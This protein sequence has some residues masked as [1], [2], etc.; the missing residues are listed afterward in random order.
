VKGAHNF[1]EHR[2]TLPLDGYALRAV[3]FRR[4]VLPG[5]HLLVLAGAQPYAPKNLAKGVRHQI[6]L[7]SK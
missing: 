7:L 2:V 3:G 1:S 4:P 6:Q 5:W